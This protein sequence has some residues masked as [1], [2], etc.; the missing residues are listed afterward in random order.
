MVQRLLPST[1][2]MSPLCRIFQRHSA[3]E[4]FTSMNRSPNITSQSERRVTFFCGMSLNVC[5]SSQRRK[6]GSKIL[7]SS[8]ASRRSS[9]SKSCNDQCAVRDET[10]LKRP[11]LQTFLIAKTCQNGQSAQVHARY[12]R[13][14]DQ[15]IY[16]NSWC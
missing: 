6:G 1:F 8:T 13:A 9:S 12:G 14:L 16:I 7:R 10:N 11:E 15:I 5:L 4:T 2:P 3:T